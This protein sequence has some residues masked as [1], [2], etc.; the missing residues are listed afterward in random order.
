G[1][2]LLTQLALMESLI[3]M[4]LSDPATDIG[5]LAVFALLT[6]FCS[7]SQDIVIDAYRVEILDERQQGAGAA[8]VV[9]GYRLGMLA[10]GAAALYLGSAF[11]CRAT[12]LVVAGLVA[13]GMATILFCRE[14]A[15]EPS[16]AWDGEACIAAACA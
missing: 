13:V 3:G 2:A 1:W 10:S 16:Q 12:Y 8:M 9:L 14:P 4:A 7:A 15:A 5:L 6:A 11:G